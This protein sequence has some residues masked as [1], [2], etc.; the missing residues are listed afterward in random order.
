MKRIKQINM[1]FKVKK[2]RDS[3]WFLKNV[4]LRNVCLK[5]VYLKSISRVMFAYG[6]VGAFGFSASTWSAGYLEMP[7]TLDVPS[8]ETDS[9]LLDLDVPP[10]R[11]R[12]PDPQGGPRLNITE[13]RLQGLVEYPE[14]G[15]TRANI[16]ERVEAIR[17]S[18]MKQD[19]LG[20]WGY[21][22]EEVSEIADMMGDLEGT[23]QDEHV[24]PLEVQKLVFL[25]REQRRRRGVTLGMIEL[26]ADEITQFYREKGFILAKA[27]IPEQ[28]VRGGVVTLTLLL[29]ELGG[30]TIPNENRVS[31]PLIKR[32]FSQYMNKPVTSER[33]EEALYLVNDIPGLRARSVLAPGSQIGDT[34]LNINIQEE[35]RYSSNVRLDNFGSEETSKNRLYGD[36]YLHNP[37]G[38]GDE[39]YVALLKTYSP[40]N[41]TFGAI[42]YSSYWGMPRLRTSIGYSTNDFISQNTQGDSDIPLFTGES[43]VA[44]ISMDYVVT[45]RRVKNITVGIK[46]SN[47]DTL[48]VSTEGSVQKT[49]LRVKFD[50]LNQ[51]R[52]HLYLGEVAL[53]SVASESL[54]FT[55]VRDIR[56][57]MLTY[58]VSRLSFPNIPFTDIPTR[59][60]LSTSGQFSGQSTS[61]VTQF[62]LTGVGRARAFSVN[63]VQGDDG[64]FASVDWIFSLPKLG[65]ATFFGAPLHTVFQPYIFADYSYGKTYAV[66]STG[67]DSVNANVADIGAGIKIDYAGVKANVFFGS[68]ILDNKTSSS[69]EDEDNTTPTSTFNFEISYAF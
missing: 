37:S 8:L 39:L 28:K 16:I 29:G 54:E 33:L 63:G 23:I 49:S 47:I 18:L 19:E 4:F 51:K 65:N 25:I 50:F 64:L 56:Y 66:D 2:M 38:L 53:H 3:L 68:V 21:T 1:K 15:I 55:G 46:H 41:S 69:E 67:T 62:N 10:L 61:N 13:F 11:D 43:Q 14:L 17:F 30:V 32:A 48:I 26:V 45:R 31:T 60:L 9:L 40:D 24:G 57:P 12:D 5:N 58:G 44:D 35:K 34:N 52:R 42:R 22:E 7:S 59:M 6:C 36:I 27:Y 20:K